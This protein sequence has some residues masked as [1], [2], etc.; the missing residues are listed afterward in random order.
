MAMLSPD[1]LNINTSFG[2]S[3]IVAIAA[4]GTARCVDR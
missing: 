3:P 2:E 4:A 1:R